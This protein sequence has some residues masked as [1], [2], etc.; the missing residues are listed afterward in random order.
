MRKTTNPQ[1]SLTALQKA[2]L[3]PRRRL[4][5]TLDSSAMILSMLGP[6]PRFWEM[7]CAPSLSS[8]LHLI[9]RKSPSR[10]SWT[11]N[12][13]CCRQTIPTKADDLLGLF[14]SSG[15]MVMHEYC[16][17]CLCLSKGSRTAVSDVQRLALS[18]WRGTTRPPSQA[19][20]SPSSSHCKRTSRS[21][22][23]MTSLSEGLHT[24]SKELP[25]LGC[26]LTSKMAKLIPP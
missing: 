19:H 24:D 22:F 11:S 17:F 18:G 2:S 3:K 1:A 8:S 7:C 10:V 12:T 20:L 15:K 6:R 5:C 26:L 21:Y 25:A 23:M 16:E 4:C 9:S 14:S 13:L